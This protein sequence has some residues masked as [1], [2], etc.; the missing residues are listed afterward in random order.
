MRLSNVLNQEKIDKY[1]QILSEI[2]EIDRLDYHLREKYLNLK[3]LLE[4]VCKEITQSETLQFPSLFSRIVFISQKFELPEYLEWNLQN[5]RVKS[6]FLQ[7]DENNV[8]SEK[9]YEVARKLIEEFISFIYLDD[10]N[11]SCSDF[12]YRNDQ[13]KLQ[14]LES[15]IRIQV[16]GIDRKNQIITGIAD[17]LS[18]LLI[19]VKY[20]IKG[21]NDIFN[22][23]I[24]KL[25]VGAQLNLINCKRDNNG[26]YIPDFFVLEPDYLIDT[27]AMAECFQN[28]GRSHLHYFLRR[29]E[30]PKNSHYILMGNLANFFLDEL[31]YAENPEELNFNDIFLKSFQQKPFEYTS[32]SDIKKVEDF[33][34]F[35]T[36]AKSQFENIR[37]VILSDFPRVGI[38]ADECIL[39]PSFYC[40]KYGFQ[41]RLDLLQMP[42]NE[43]ESYNIVELKSGG[44]PY[45]KEDSGKISINHEVQT[46]IYRLII[47]S[48]FGINARRIYSSIL[49]SAAENEG[50]NLR[51][52]AV[53][54]TLEKEIVNIRNLI[55]ATEHELYTGDNETVE[56]LFSEIFDLSNYGRIPNF[57]KDRIDD[58][59]KIINNLDST[60]KKYFYRFFVFLS[61]EL[62][63]HKA[64]DNGIESANST[65]SLWN[66]DFQT[67]KESFDIISDLEI[68]SIDESGRD[69]K[70][71]FRRN[72][73]L[74]FINFREGEICILYPHT[75]STDTVLTN[76]IFKGTISEIKPD[77]TLL[78]FRYKQ[79]NHKIFQKHSLWVVEH[80]RL[81]HAYNNM[82]K[83]LF[84]FIASPKRKRQLLLGIEKVQS[85]Y[86]GQNIP[87]DESSIISK[88]H[89]V[90]QKAVAAKDYFLIV[91]PPGT[92]KTSVY[93]K[94]LIEHYYNH[95]E[96]NILI[97]AY[98]NRAVDELCEAIHVAFGCED[99]ECEHYIRIGTELSCGEKY[100]SR[101]LQFLSEGVKSRQELNNILLN[102][103]IF[104]GTLA[105]IIGKP[106][107]FD[108]KIFDICIIDEA[109]QILE[110]QIIGLLSKVRKF[111][112]I[113][114]HKQ[115]STITLQDEEK[116]KVN[117]LQLNIIELY[118]CDESIFERLYRISRKNGWES[119]YETL[120]YQGRMHEELAAFPNRT[121]YQNILKPI[122]RWQSEDLNWVVEED[123]S[124]LKKMI[125][126]NRLAFISCYEKNFPLNDK[127]NYAEAD[128][129]VQLCR[130]I[131][132]MYS[133]NSLLFD[134]QKT[135]GIITPYR[136]QIA[137]I[138]HQLYKTNVSAFENIMVD[139]VERF[140]GSQRD[141]IIY[142]FC[143]NKPYQLEFL[144]NLNIDKTVDRK[145]NVALTRARKQ[146]FLIGNE[147]LLRQNYFYRLLLD[148]C[149][150]YH[151]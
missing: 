47:Q 31:V 118:R 91:G 46:T 72:D 21:V 97:L 6:S 87:F 101:L 40:E 69:M 58:F 78:R 56:N 82:Y 108:L 107:I 29:F 81:D 116:S 79:K 100:R 111:I 95:T 13:P 65:A 5:I 63:I 74:D 109:S 19:Q 28:Y 53:Y 17:D 146:L 90:I 128:T 30:Q 80:D 66:T 88:Q 149:S 86:E 62:Y 144:S 36:K 125:A 93:A 121:F 119:V 84:D 142:S 131:Y 127:I 137:L 117:D 114:D 1:N 20:N 61:R 98:T 76:Q 14:K 32:C 105:S 11:I 67:R 35:M 77:K 64:G 112:M 39:E 96:D 135:L 44:L 143:V 23:T 15:K 70:I 26:Y 113:G 145:L 12:E 4:R 99:A 102:Q 140:Q 148:S 132:E 71:L 150:H 38:N 48:V 136:N 75:L 18:S 3:R 57:F 10:N 51:L 138:K 89:T 54:H 52:A 94:K 120:I 60:E 43:E 2:E 151:L 110:P 25:W 126:E 50:E 68:V 8:I 22:S 34:A 129:V 92:G 134:S 59:E 104:I 139:T 55:I 41:G 37:R 106:E 122:N 115:L 123:T 85:D 124:P 16:T 49:Y 141:I 130:A 133:E 7:K 83:N 24:D 27:S 45:P 9:D 147:Y 103:R 73:N 33:K 42:E